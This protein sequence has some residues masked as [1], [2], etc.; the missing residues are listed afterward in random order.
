MSKKSLSDDVG[1]SNETSE[2]TLAALT[3]RISIFAREATLDSRCAAKLI[4]RVK[5]EAEIISDRGK[6]TKPGQKVLKKA[7]DAVDAELREHDAGLL[8]TADAA[9]RST[10]DATDARESR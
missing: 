6:T 5:R 4:K 2:G 7:F 10:D 3:M 8:V 9:L 1:D